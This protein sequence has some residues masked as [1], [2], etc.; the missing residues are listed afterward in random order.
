MQRDGTSFLCGSLILNFIW[1]SSLSSD[2]L[3]KPAGEQ[4]HHATC[5]QKIA[6]LSHVKS[7]DRLLEPM[8]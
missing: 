5:V 8:A 7:L 4:K 1:L 6:T 3:G 2:A